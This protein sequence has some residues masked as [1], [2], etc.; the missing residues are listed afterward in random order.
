MS[1][2]KQKLEFFT[3]KMDRLNDLESTLEQ[4]KDKITDAN[5]AL[6]NQ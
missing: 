3:S 4:Y 1:A 6:E 5:E 2:M